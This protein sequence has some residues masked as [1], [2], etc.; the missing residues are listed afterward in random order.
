MRPAL[1]FTWSLE[2]IQARLIDA[3]EEVFAL[4]GLTGDDNLFH[5][6]SHPQS[7]MRVLLAMELRLGVTLDEDIYDDGDGRI[8]SVAAKILARLYP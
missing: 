3:C 8:A 4:K 1:A 6:G 7:T 5:L 2:D